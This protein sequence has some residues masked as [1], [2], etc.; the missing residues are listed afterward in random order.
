[1]LCDN[2]R[3]VMFQMIPSYG[4]WVARWNSPT[5]DGNGNCQGS[6]QNMS[7]T[8]SYGVDQ[9][10][11]MVLDLFKLVTVDTLLLSVHHTT[12]VLD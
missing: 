3:L 11:D 9:G 10:I 7:W 12:M 6:V 8:T 1:M 4:S 2:D 5:V